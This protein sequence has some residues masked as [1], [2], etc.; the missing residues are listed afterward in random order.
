MP[1]SDFMMRATGQART[2]ENDLTVEL[3]SGLV[4]EVG[5]LTP[6]ALA[7]RKREAHRVIKKCGTFLL[8][9]LEKELEEDAIELLFEAAGLGTDTHLSSYE[10]QIKGE[11]EHYGRKLTPR[12]R[13]V[14]RAQRLD[15]VIKAIWAFGCGG[16]RANEKQVHAFIR[17][18]HPEQ[19]QFNGGKK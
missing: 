6:L 2:L 18:H 14:D 7:L 9:R 1:L 15:I 8:I 16:C 12:E 13:L 10:T 5:L 3:L 19:D 17:L 4:T 11:E